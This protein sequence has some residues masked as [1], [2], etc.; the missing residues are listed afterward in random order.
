[1]PAEYVPDPELDC[2]HFIAGSSIVLSV[3]QRLPVIY[4]IWIHG[5]LKHAI[6]SQL[7]DVCFQCVQGSIPSML[8]I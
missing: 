3:W 7:V 8:G 4:V 5:L 2:N 6:V 1:M